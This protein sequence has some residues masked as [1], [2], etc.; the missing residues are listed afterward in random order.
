MLPVIYQSTRR[1]TPERFNLH[2]LLFD[3]AGGQTT[4]QKT[5]NLVGSTLMPRHL[6]D[7]LRAVKNIELHK[8]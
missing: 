5:K 1:N 8:T 4:S 3:K 7:L 2:V 6:S